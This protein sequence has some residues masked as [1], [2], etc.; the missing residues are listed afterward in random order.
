MS[1]LVGQNLILLM[2]PSHR[3]GNTECGVSVNVFFHIGIEMQNEGM[4]THGIHY[5]FQKRTLES[6]A[7]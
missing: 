4:S 1:F 5:I 6:G 7:F 2:S 3:A